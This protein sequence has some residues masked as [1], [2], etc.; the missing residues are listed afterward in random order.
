MNEEL[1]KELVKTK[2]TILDSLIHLLP[3]TIQERAVGLQQSIFRVIREVVNEYD[4]NN[5]QSQN[6]EKELRSIEIG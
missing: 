3:P 5:T 1:I 4:P 2:L 6:K